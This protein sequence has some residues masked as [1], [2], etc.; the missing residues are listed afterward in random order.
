[1]SNNQEE[2]SQRGQQQAPALLDSTRLGA[3]P[4]TS[5]TE[6]AGQPEQMLPLKAE[7]LAAAGERMLSELQRHRH[8]DAHVDSWNRK[9]NVLKKV[10]AVT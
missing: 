8:Y 1:M 10:W 6:T 9:H 2:V 3:L 5:G 7:A 4:G